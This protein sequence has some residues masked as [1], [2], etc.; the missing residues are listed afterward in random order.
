MTS[1]ESIKYILTTSQKEH[2]KEGAGALR[3]YYIGFLTTLCSNLPKVMI[4]KTVDTNTTLSITVSELVLQVTFYKDFKTDR[5]CHRI[6]MNTEDANP[7]S[8]SIVNYFNKCLREVIR[9][10]PYSDP[11]IY[12]NMKMCSTC[13]THKPNVKKCACKA[14]WYCSVDCQ[15][16]DWKNHKAL[17]KSLLC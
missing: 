14:K 12:E 1:T 13:N 4:D 9:T 16:A 2:I 3:G 10:V 6:S 11:L 17:C 15:K 5:C 8:I 7:R